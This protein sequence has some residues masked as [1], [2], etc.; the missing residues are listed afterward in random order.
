MRGVSLDAPITLAFA[1]GPKLNKGRLAGRVVGADRGQPRAKV[2]VFA[3]AA[4][5]SS[6]LD[7]LPSRPAY[8]TQ[9][10]SN[11]RF[12]F[13]YLR[14][15]PYFVV[16]LSDRNANQQIDPGEPFAAPPRPLIFADTLKQQRDTLRWIMTRRDERP[17][18]AQRVRVQSRR[19]F[20]VSFNEAVLLTSRAPD[21]WPL[22]DSL[23]AASETVRQVYMRSQ[24]P[25]RVFLTT[26]DT[27]RSRPHWIAPG[28]AADSSGQPA[29]P[30]TLRFDPSGAPPDTAQL[31]FGGFLPE[32]RTGGR[33]PLVLGPRQHI[34]LRFN[35]PPPDSLPSFVTITASA[36]TDTTRADTARASATGRP[37]SFFAQTSSGTVYR[38]RPDPPLSPDS[39]LTVRVTLPSRP[40]T[41]YRRRYKRLSEREVGGVLGTRVFLPWKQASS[42]PCASCRPARIACGSSGI[43]TRTARGTAGSSFHT[44][45]RNRSAGSP[46]RST[47]APAGIRSWT[48]FDCRMASDEW[49]RAKFYRRACRERGRSEL[50]VAQVHHIQHVLHVKIEVQ[51]EKRDRR[52]RPATFR[53]LIFRPEIANRTWN[54]FSLPKP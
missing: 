5:D 47:C 13:K 39:T 20:G 9:A 19:R 34:R 28:G 17:P 35:L 45:R 16:A 11:G 4:P 52:D 38:L 15:Q 51:R 18:V 25:R 27:M 22:T 12:T 46:N 1:T 10:G 32:R 14:E 37:R 21:A 23:P 29:R 54:L 53:L 50:Q 8:R 41:T 7:S 48:R 3:Y 33:G 24:A 40:D 44:R 2:N 26:T 30:D 49:R 6:R 42:S 36:G 43:R 31:R